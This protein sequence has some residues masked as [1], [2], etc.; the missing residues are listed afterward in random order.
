MSEVVST[1]VSTYSRELR[2]R[3]VTAL[4]GVSEYQVIKFELCDESGNWH[5]GETVETPKI[6]GDTHSQ[7][8]AELE[9]DVIGLIIGKEISEAIQSIKESNL[10]GSTKAAVDITL[11][12]VIGKGVRQEFSVAT[13]VTIPIT[14]I[15]N[16]PAL[17]TDRV[18]SGFTYFK[19][20][21]N[22]EPVADLIAKLQ[23]INELAP[24][25]SHIR[26]DA[27]QAWDFEHTAEVLAAISES[28]LVID[29]LEQP[30]SARDFAALAKVKVI[31]AIPIMADESCFTPADL[32][33]LIALNAMDLVN[34]KLLKSGGLSVAREMAKTA[35]TAGIGVYVGSMM[36]G[37]QS[38]SAAATFA[39]EIAPDLVHDLDAS[40]WAKESHL[41]YESGRLYL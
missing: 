20:K 17:V 27:N 34:L 1:R 23:L 35:A 5:V 19:V 32:T 25:G 2:E 15:E 24:S 8:M 40:W 26:I 13:D 9:S 21:A 7:I 16:L 30:T 29:Y 31:S 3:F 12:S 6:T 41:R 11:N 28:G 22:T 18:A 14:S 39:S 4:R 36:E 37:D 33:E 10:T 38:L